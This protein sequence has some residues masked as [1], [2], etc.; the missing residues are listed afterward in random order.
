MNATSRQPRDEAETL[1][2]SIVQY[3]PKRGADA[4]EQPKPAVAVDDRTEAERLGD[5]IS[6]FLSRREASK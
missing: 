3:L 1:A 4:S 6:E 2:A 5:Q